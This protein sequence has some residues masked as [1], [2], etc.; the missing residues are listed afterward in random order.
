M[1]VRR[2]RGGATAG[3]LTPRAALRARP[4]AGFQR[5]CRPAPAPACAVGEGSVILLHPPPSPFSIGV[6]IGLERGDVSAMTEISPTARPAQPTGVAHKRSPPPWSSS[7]GLRRCAAAGPPRPPAQWLDLEQQP[8]Q[9][10]A[11]ALAAVPGA[12]FAGTSWGGGGQA[13]VPPVLWSCA[14]RTSREGARAAPAASLAHHPA[15]S[16]RREF[17]H[18]D[19]TPCLS[20][21]KH[22]M[23]VQGG[24]IK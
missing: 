22:L 1:C 5:A 2:G 12:G 19:D 23:K 17:C 21:L 4:A 14:S 13:S 8:W 9:Q 18:F 10:L 20:L 16:R 3:A 24:A 15:D 6:S 11:A 7:S